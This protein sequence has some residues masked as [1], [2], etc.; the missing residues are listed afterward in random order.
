MLEAQAVAAA[1]GETMAVGVDARIAGA[2]SVG[3]HETSMLQDLEAGREMEVDAV[4]GA[5]AELA[6]IAGVAT[7][8]LDALLGMIRLLATAEALRLGR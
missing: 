8:A 3:A 4:V 5:V 1:F 7:P 6:R 2:E